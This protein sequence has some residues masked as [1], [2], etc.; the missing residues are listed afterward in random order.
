MADAKLSQLMT[1]SPATVAAGAA[2]WLFPGFIQGLRMVRTA[3][4]ALRVDPGAAFIESL[5][6]ALNVPAAITKIGLTLTANT[7]YHVY[8]YSNNGEPDIEVV[9]AAPAAAYYG[10]ARSKTGDT[11]RR[12]VGSVRCGATANTIIPFFHA[13]ETGVVKYVNDI[14]S[15][16][17]RVLA[18]GRTAVSVTVGCSAVVPET[19]RVMYA[20]AEN[21]DTTK[22]A[23]IGSPELGP[24]SPS[25]I[26]EYL[27]PKGVMFGEMILDASQQFNYLCDAADGFGL[28]VW[29]TGYTYER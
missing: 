5:G 17:L 3:A 15:D 6:Y 26:L 4:N 9:T 10:T 19:G 13:P 8:L 14:N 21:D 20:F 27:R 16:G 23:F 28:S 1:V 18:S 29:A 22:I 7:W 24:A 12:Y 2:L 25:A 11:S